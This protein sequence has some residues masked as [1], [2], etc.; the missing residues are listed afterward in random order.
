[1]LKFL[2]WNVGKKSIGNLVGS[3]AAERDI[4]LIVLAECSTPLE[5]LRELNRTS[6]RNYFH[7]PSLTGKIHTYS[8]LP[9]GSI[10][11]LVEYSGLAIHQVHPPIGKD[12]LLVGVHLPSKMHMN[13]DDQL[14][15]CTTLVRK[16]TSFEQRVGH[17]R[18][19]V[20]GDFNLNP[21]EEAL[22]AAHCFHAASS[23][24]IAARRQRIIRGESYQF[25][26]NPMWNHFG[27]RGP[28]PPGT[29]Y[30]ERSAPT[31]LFWNMFDQVLLRP[32]VMDQF[33]DNSLE[34]LTSVGGYS[35]LNTNGRPNKSAGSDH[36][37]IFFSLNFILNGGSDA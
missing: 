12:F 13:S 6:P 18:T 14:L 23:R 15:E 25:F 32:E 26:Y 7:S 36:L 24:P 37:P 28:S 11:P 35:L 21:F 17:C 3:I 4:D 16:I 2:F 5:T 30:Y 27:D 10:T 33:D 34:I 20:V 9:Q 29:Y 1:M 8:C 19:I 31:D 22:V